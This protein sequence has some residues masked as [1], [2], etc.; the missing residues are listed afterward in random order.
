M[1]GA[2]GGVIRRWHHRGVGGVT[3]LPVTLG[4]GIAGLSER[5]N[6]RQS[7]RSLAHDSSRRPPPGQ[8]LSCTQQRGAMQKP[9]RLGNLRVPDLG[10]LAWWFTS[11][12]EPPGLGLLE[13]QAFLEE[14]GQFRCR[15][16]YW[17]S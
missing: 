16:I 11:G 17:P 4:T 12:D 3:R 5:P 9:A 14:L 8:C 6:G 1:R 15:M 13:V 2:T 10:A 7:I